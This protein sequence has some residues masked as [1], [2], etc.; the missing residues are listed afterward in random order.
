VR[1]V[2]SIGLERPIHAIAGSLFR[3]TTERPVFHLTYDD[4]PH[5]TITP[6]ILDVLD[7]FEAH[8][9]FFVL[10][11]NAQMFPDLIHETMRR[12]HDIALHT[13]THPRLTEV[14][15]GRLRDEICAARRDLEEVAGIEVEWFRPPYG[16]QN[17]RSLSVVKA[18]GMQTVLWSVDSRDWKGLTQEN[19]LAKSL[20]GLEPGGILLLH[21]VPV[22]ESEMEDAAHGYLPKDELTRM[23]LDELAERGLEPVSLSSLLSSGEPLRRAKFG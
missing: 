18:C 12:G 7:E 23:F 13:R 19:P 5:P 14:P 22:G 8:A 16:A 4:G 3:V 17:I 1:F 10:T 21:D 2:R 15:L 6:R 9:T 11:D 20:K